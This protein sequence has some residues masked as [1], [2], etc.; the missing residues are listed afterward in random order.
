MEPQWDEPMNMPE[1][2]TEE[3][4]T[5]GSA[6][7]FLPPG[8]PTLASRWKPTQDFGLFTEVTLKSYY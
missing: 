2:R 7:E 6:A 1:G 4:V 3:D 5:R 8:V